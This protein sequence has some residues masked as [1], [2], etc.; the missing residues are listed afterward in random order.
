M[1]KVTINGEVFEFDQTRKPMAE[2]LALE[3]ALGMPYGQWEEAI[4]Q[5]SARAMCGF[6]WLVWRRAGRDTE[7]KDLLDGTI[8]IDLNAI[9]IA[10]DGDAPPDPTST[11]PGPAASPTTGTATSPRSAASTSA[12]GRSASST[13]P[14]SKP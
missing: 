4:G 9:E 14:T 10:E 11:G 7:L 8:D 1:A 2:A 5:G 3:K 6:I 13:R 12:R